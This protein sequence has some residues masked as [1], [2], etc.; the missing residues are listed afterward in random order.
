VIRR[1]YKTIGVI[2]IILGIAMLVFGT[3]IFGYQGKRLSQIISD[4]GFFS[5]ILWLPTIIVGIVFIGVKKK[6]K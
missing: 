5:F 1:P 6:L 4:L 3:S 2:L